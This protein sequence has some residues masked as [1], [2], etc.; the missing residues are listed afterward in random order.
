MAAGEHAAAAS[1][2]ARGI[3]PDVTAELRKPLTGHSAPLHIPGSP[4]MVSRGSGS[5]QPQAHSAP[6]RA[7]RSHDAA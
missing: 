4:L 3:D 6:R 2:Y 5:A 1:V 7:S